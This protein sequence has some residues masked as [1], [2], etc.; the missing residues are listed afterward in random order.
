MA[1]DP[2]YYRKTTFITHD[3]LYA[4]QCKPFGLG[5]ASE[6]IRSELDEIL[7]KYKQ[8]TCL[9]YIDELVLFS[10]IVDE[11]ITRVDEMR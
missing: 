5:N 6:T 2:Q 9:V 4:G 1:I 8:K 3:I 10:K 7:D 11:H